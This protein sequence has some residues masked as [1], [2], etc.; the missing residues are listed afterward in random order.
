[1]S[2]TRDQRGL[3]GSRLTVRV[4]I[5]LSM[6]IVVGRRRP[7][8]GHVDVGDGRPAAARHGRP[9]MMQL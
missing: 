2:S 5:L 1:V 4:T 9:M 8:D 7:V 3:A 6:L